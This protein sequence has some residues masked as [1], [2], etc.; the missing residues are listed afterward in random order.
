MW[1]IRICFI[2]SLLIASFAARAAD[3]LADDVPIPADA[4]I[5]SVPPE[6]P[7]TAKVFSGAWVGSW[8]GRL[9]HVLIVENIDRDGV[10]RVL[11]AVGDNPDAGI[12][13]QWRRYQ[14][15]VQ[16]DT[17]T[18][19]SVFT[20]T[21]KFMPSDKLSATFRRGNAVVRAMLSRLNVRDL[22]PPRAS[23]PWTRPV[24]FL[25]TKLREDGHPVRLEVV[26]EKP[27]SNGP[28]PLLVFNHG[29]TGTG[30]QPDAFS[31]TSW[32]QDIADF[33]VKRG[34]IVAFPQ[35]RGRGKSDGVYDEGF[36]GDRTRGYTCDPPSSLAGAERALEDIEAAVEALELR[37]D[38]ARNRILVG[39]QSRGG[40]LS[41]VY[42]ANHPEQVR[43][44]IN[45]VGGWVGEP[46]CGP[47]SEINRTLF[48][49]GAK[50]EGPTL[51]LY[52]QNDSVYSIGYSRSNFEAFVRAGG[53]GDFVELDVPNRD[54]HELIAHPEQWVGSVEKYVT[55]I[56]ETKH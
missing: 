1:W 41:I 48:Q 25:N 56:S 32:S 17:L 2:V 5:A 34:W 30:R 10:A 9:H 31:R 19:A 44:V 29:S 42:A 53:H 20:A 36:A 37:P 12:I 39:G 13:H 52:G 11:Y 15:T 28:F 55:A 45:F 38:V 22:L 35:R 40:V 21:Y 26:I 18:I 23:I 16:G 14:G 4:Q 6:T 50:W 8:G 47:A 54:G 7:E 27:T 46:G 51:W 3:L 33:F 24:E 49:R 43:G